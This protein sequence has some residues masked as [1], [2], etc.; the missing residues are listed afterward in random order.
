[1]VV[2]PKRKLVIV[3]AG[4][5]AAVAA[6]VVVCS[7]GPERVSEENF[8]RIRTG[9]SQPEVCAILGPPG[10][11]TNQPLKRVF[12]NGHVN[13]VEEQQDYCE[14]WY[15]DRHAIA[16]FWHNGTLRSTKIADCETYQLS[17]I[18]Q[19]RWRLWRLWCHCLK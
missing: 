15:G 10:D 9:M 6:G 16:C 19:I 7:P 4:L 13:L 5:A 8:E 12:W 3:L 17:P 1:V 11:Y 14:I 18:E 2:A